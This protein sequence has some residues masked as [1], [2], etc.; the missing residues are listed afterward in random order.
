MS[1][2]PVPAVNRAIFM[3]I[4]IKSKK[5]NNNN[6]KEENKKENKY[7]KPKRR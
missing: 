4:I 1:S 6:K 2:P 5:K 7:L 3:Y